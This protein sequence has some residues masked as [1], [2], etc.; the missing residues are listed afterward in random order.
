MTLLPVLCTVILLIFLP[1]ANKIRPLFEVKAFRDIG[2]L[3]YSFYLWHFPILAFGRYYLYPVYQWQ[4]VALIL[5]SLL[6]SWT[7]FNIIENPIRRIRSNRMFFWLLTLL[8][9]ISVTA[10]TIGLWTQSGSMKSKT[11]NQVKV[12][13]FITHDMIERP[14][15]SGD[16]ESLNEKPII[17]FIG[18]SHV[19]PWGALSS[20][21]KSDYQVV[22]LSYLRCEFNYASGDTM[23]LKSVNGAQYAPTCGALDNF[24]RR[25]DLLT[26]VSAI[27]LMSNRPLTYSDNTFRF[28]L[29]KTISLSSTLSPQIFV[30]G[31]YFQLSPMFIGCSKLMERKTTS[32]AEVCIDYADNFNPVVQLNELRLYR[33][34]IDAIDGQYIDLFGLLKSASNSYPVEY[35]SVPFMYDWNHLTPEFIF[36]IGERLVSYQ[37]SDGATNNLRAFLK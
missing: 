1:Y 18:D 27:F 8:F 15:Q 31:N 6:L 25:S 16:F 14:R 32:S 7:S 36:Y 21:V 35:K 26:R 2:K 37:G 30:F 5:V 29:I 34:K 24:L 12:P 17:L 28:D 11:I 23:H 20:F 3:S 19:E 4:V 9:F 22:S 10:A 13:S 33:E